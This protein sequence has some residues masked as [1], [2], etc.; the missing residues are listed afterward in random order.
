MD[1]IRLIILKTLIRFYH[2]GSSAQFYDRRFLGYGVILC[3][4]QVG[5]EY[6]QNTEVM[7]MSKD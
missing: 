6:K 1:Y 7:E 4:L 5:S 2:A 3:G